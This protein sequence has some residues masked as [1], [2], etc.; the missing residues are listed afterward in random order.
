ML[1]HIKIDSDNGSAYG[2]ITHHIIII[3]NGKTAFLEPQPSLDDSARH[4][5]VFTSWDFVTIIH[6]QTK[7]VS[8]ASD[9]PH[10]STNH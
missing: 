5:P 10:T 9:S 8:L 2:L 1:I 3:I 4:D 6:S 7:V